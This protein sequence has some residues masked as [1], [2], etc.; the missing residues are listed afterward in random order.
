MIQG[1]P[2]YLARSV[3]LGAVLTN[4]DAFDSG[5]SMPELTGTALDLYIQVHGRKHYE[6]YNDILPPIPED[7]LHVAERYPSALRGWINDHTVRHGI[8]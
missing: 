2:K 4:K 8:V 5:V 7:L 3:A 1:T 6:S